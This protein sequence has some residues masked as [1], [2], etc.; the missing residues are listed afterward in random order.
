M[1][2]CNETDMDKSISILDKDYCSGCRNSA[3]VINA[4]K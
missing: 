4:A 2:K 3:S 1:L